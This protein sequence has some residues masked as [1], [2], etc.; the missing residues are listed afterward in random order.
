MKIFIHPSYIFLK[1]E[2]LRIVREGYSPDKVYSNKRNLVEKVTIA[3]KPYVIK[4][5]KRPTLANCFIYTF[6]RKTKAQRAYEYALMLLERGVKT[7]FPVAYIE[8]KKNGFFHTGY[9][10]TEYMD[11]P[12]LS[13]FRPDNLPNDELMKL[14][15]S[16]IDFTIGLQEKRI[17]P[18]DYNPGNIFYYYNSAKGCYEFALTDINRMRFGYVPWTRDTMR[19][20]EQFGISTEHLYKF[21]L[22]YSKERGV[23]IDFCMYQFLSFRLRKK[24]RRYIKDKMKSKIKRKGLK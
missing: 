22:E 13:E 8:V 17:L 19:S 2:L 16:F 12:T 23:D 20:F 6:F 11:Y 5:F 1:S 9:L 24:I 7:P 10:I 3:G 4:R 15:S 14:Q 18:L 21:M